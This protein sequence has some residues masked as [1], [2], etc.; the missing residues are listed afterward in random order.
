VMP[1]RK[2]V[3]ITMEGVGEEADSEE[4]REE[5]ATDSGPAPPGVNIPERYN[6]NSELTA[7]VA[8]DQREF[9]FHLKSH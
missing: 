1:G 5:S 8:P 3:R 4:D 7:D 6:R 2:I 9:D